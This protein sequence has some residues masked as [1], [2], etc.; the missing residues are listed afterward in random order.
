MKHVFFGA[1]FCMAVLG[2]IVVAHAAS[3]V[4]LARVV[5]VP[6]RAT[7]TMLGTGLAGLVFWKGRQ[8]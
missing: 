1:L 6:K 7:I 3:A 2:S 5:V 4:A 8:K